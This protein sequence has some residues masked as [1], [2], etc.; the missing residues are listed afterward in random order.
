MEIPFAPP[1]LNQEDID[2]V[3]AVLRSGWITTGPVS[4]QFEEELADYCGTPHVVLQSSC[5]TGLESALRLAGVG[6]GDDVLVPAYTFTASAA[7]PLHVGA[8]VILVDNEDGRFTPSPE[9]FLRKLTPSTKAIVTVDFA[10]VP[11]PSDVLISLLETKNHPYSA[12]AF[13][14]L[15][16][17]VVISDAAHSLGASRDGLRVGQI[18]DLTAFSF[19]AVKNLTTA[20]GGALTWRPGLTADSR[21]LSAIVHRDSLHGQTKDARQKNLAGQWE[22]DIVTPGYKGNLPDV[23]AALGLSQLQRYESIIRRRL[24]IIGEYGERLKGAVELL[25][26]RGPNFTSSGHLAVATLPGYT[27][28]ERNIVIASLAASGVS[29]N[30]HYKPLPLL[31]AYNKLGFNAEDFP[32]AVKSYSNEITLPLFNDMTESQIGFVCEQLRE[33]TRSLDR[34]ER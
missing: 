33:A 17:P 15:K 22:Y 7:A 6:K 31:T 34:S 4:Q 18:A 27:E 10:G 24:E 13:D 32:N 20:E 25:P 28:K 12:S 30:V 23:L 9:H 8:N 29:A 3:L 11:Y 16:R 19:H 5:T 26:H 21:E 1:S 2:A 14:Q